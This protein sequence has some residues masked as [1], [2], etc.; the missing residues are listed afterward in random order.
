MKEAKQ[1]PQAS[2]GGATGLIIVLVSLA[3]V[4]GIVAL[5]ITGD[6]GKITGA[7]TYRQGSQDPW[8]I[9]VDWCNTRSDIEPVG[10]TGVTIS[11]YY[12]RVLSTRQDKAHGLYLLRNTMANLGNDAMA[13]AQ[14]PNESPTA[15]DLAWLKA[16]E[17]NQWHLQLNVPG[18]ATPIRITPAMCKRFAIAATLNSSRGLPRKMGGSIDIECTT[19]DGAQVLAKVTYNGCP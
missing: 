19:A 8:Q 10:V 1:T 7:I 12:S 3:V 14:G 9:D 5:T 13:I 15:K 17:Q 18:A 16:Y 4:G 2:K 11:S 6:E